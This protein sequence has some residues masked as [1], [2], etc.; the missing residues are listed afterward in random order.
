MDLNRVYDTCRT[1]EK[2]ATS[3]VTSLM[4]VTREIINLGSRSSAPYFSGKK[5]CNNKVIVEI[6]TTG[7]T[8]KT[9]YIGV[10]QTTAVQKNQRVATVNHG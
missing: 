8:P 3:H 5:E 7:G 6:Q 2:N 9:G 10:I 4:S 1:R